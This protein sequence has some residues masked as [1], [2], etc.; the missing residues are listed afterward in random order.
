[1]PISRQD[2]AN[3]FIRGRIG[4]ARAAGILQ[5][6]LDSARSL[7][8]ARNGLLTLPDEGGPA[9][10]FLCSG[11]TAKAVQRLWELPDA[12][13]LF[14]RPGIIAVPLRLPDLSGYIRAPGLPE[15]RL[16]G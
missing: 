16:P 11:M 7:T 1:M 2:C 4:D 15:F 8:G 14:K 13:K 3:T 5:S 6:V 12:L 10:D 9:A